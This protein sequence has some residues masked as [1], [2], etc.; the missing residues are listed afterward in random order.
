[1]DSG[2]DIH[3]TSATHGKCG[4][5]PMGKTILSHL[6]DLNLNFVYILCMNNLPNPPSMGPT[7]SYL[8]G[9]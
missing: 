3:C 1:M 7:L 9:S 6:G 5:F 4:V 8:W 2:D